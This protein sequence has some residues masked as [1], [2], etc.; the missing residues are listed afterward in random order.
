M[1]SNLLQTGVCDPQHSSLSE[2]GNALGSGRVSLLRLLVFAAICFASFSSRAAAPEKSKLAVL[3]RAAASDQVLILEHVT[4]IDVT[5][6]PSLA[7][8]SVIVSG[9]SITAIAKFGSIPIPAGAHVIDGHGKFL[10]PGLWDMHT[11]V[12]G[13]AA[14]PSWAKNTLLPLLVANGITGIR[15]MGGD[16]DALE[17]WRREVEVGTL[18]GPRIVAAGPMLV[19]ARRAGA[20]LRRPIRRCCASARP[21]KPARPSTACKSAARISSKSSRLARETISRSRR[22]RKKMES[23]SS[24][25]FPR[26]QCHRG[27]ERRTEKHRA[28]HLQFA[29][30]RLLRAG[31]GNSAQA[32]AKR[33]PR[34]KSEPM[35]RFTMKRTNFF[36]RESS[37]AMAYVQKERHMGDANSFLHLGERASF[38]RDSA[39]GSAAR[40]PSA[41]VAERSGRPRKIPRR[42]DRGRKRGGSASLKTIANSPVKCIARAF[43][44]WREAIRSTATILWARACI[45]NCKC[46]SKP[47][48]RRSKRCRRQRSGPPSSWP[49]QIPAKSQR[50]IARIWFCSRATPRK[51]SAIRRKSQRWC[52]K[53]GCM[54]AGNSMRCFP[55]RVQQ[56]RPLQPRPAK[57]SKRNVSAKACGFPRITQ[58]PRGF[59]QTYGQIDHCLEPLRVGGRQPV[60]M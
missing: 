6:G 33:W 44:C 52:C 35:P 49:E 14:D 38:A 13:I 9:D 45:A 58:A 56:R 41:S 32:C 47:A 8:R 5:G 48:S 40:L 1:R 17:E 50:A 4:V 23:R 51:T 15:D 21:K 16:L 39:D 34:K 30:A 37:R 25:T 27:V 36:A 20:R 54:R 3:Y 29:R 53:D 43:A 12:A 7:D 59:A 55:G 24:G 26:R 11:H 18:A 46:L 60:A 57:Q 42:S 28:H 22:N 31:R 2:P 10:I 19:P